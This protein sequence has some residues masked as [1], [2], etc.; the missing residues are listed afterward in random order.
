MLAYVPESQSVPKTTPNT[1]VSVAANAS[2]ALVFNQTK[3]RSAHSQS[4]APRNVHSNHSHT[5]VNVQKKDWFRKER[6]ASSKDLSDTCQVFEN[7]CHSSG[8]WWY[9]PK[10]GAE[11]PDFTLLTKLRGAPNAYPSEVRVFHS[12][13]DAR[14]RNRTCHESP[15]TN[16]IS[17][18][19]VYNMMLGEFY[20]RSLPVLHEIVQTQVDHIDDFLANTQMYVHMYDRNDKSMLDFHHAFTDAFRGH[21]LLDFKSLLDNAG[22]QCLPRLTMWLPKQYR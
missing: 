4:S 11:Q 18:H 13:V 7:V 14:M 1:S 8:R 5:A 15:I 20:S 21:P 22:C 6:F 12:D 9:K 2:T 16:H 17:I 3:S 10:D 19:S